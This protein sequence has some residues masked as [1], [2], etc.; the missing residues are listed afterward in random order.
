MKLVVVSGRSGSGK[1]SAL[2]V[3]EDLG[4]YCVDNLPVTLLPEL[5]RTLAASSTGNQQQVA[6]GVDARNLPEDLKHFG[7]IL[8]DIRNQQV[9][10][11]VVYLDARDE[12]LIQRFHSTRRKHPLSSPSQSLNEAIGSEARLLDSVSMQ[13]TL[14]L[15]TS[16]FNIH[17][18]REEFR[19]RMTSLQGGSLAMLLESFAYKHGVPVDADFVFDVRCLPN[20][21]WQ[22]ELRQQSG[23]DRGVMGFLDAHTEVQKYLEDMGGFLD[24]WLPAFNEG[25]RSYLTVAFGCTGGQHRSVYIAERMAERLHNSGYS[26]VQVR[27]RELAHHDRGE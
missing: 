8:Q 13:A 4:F 25:D 23:L 24:T 27:H 16:S 6:V 3:L 26:L 10:V 7:K 18:L 5:T 1:T 14:R 11:E 19:R 9:A 12:I 17:E 21:H 2:H 22:V 20:P 15:D